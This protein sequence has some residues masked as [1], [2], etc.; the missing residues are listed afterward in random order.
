MMNIPT[1]CIFAHRGASGAAPENTLSA[2][3]LALDQGAHAIELDAKLSLD[4][5]IVVIHDPTLGRT[6]NG[7][8]FVHQ[9]SYPDLRNLD[10]GSWFSSQYAGEDSSAFRGTGECR[11]QNDHQH[12]NYPLSHLVGRIAPKTFDVNQ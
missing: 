11:Q 7:S 4:G 1:P 5:K 3:K 10:A 6:T 9:T 12:R 2:F 8:G